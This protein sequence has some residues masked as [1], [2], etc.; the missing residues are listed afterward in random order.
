MTY[1]LRDKRKRNRDLYQFYLDTKE[2]ELTFRE[3]GEKF[4]MTGARAFTI[5]KKEEE[6]VKSEAK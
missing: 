3:I 4:G 1:K 6:R 2:K 5:I